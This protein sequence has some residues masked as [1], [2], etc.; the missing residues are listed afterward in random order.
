MD[1]GLGVN[2]SVIWDTTDGTHGLLGVRVR[3]SGLGNTT[4]GTLGLG[5]LD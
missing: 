5:Y 2:L 3:L 4:N 1:A